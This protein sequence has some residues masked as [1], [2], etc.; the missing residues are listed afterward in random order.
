MP[1]LTYRVIVLKA[2]CEL[3]VINCY[4]Y[5][6]ALETHADLLGEYPGLH[7]YIEAI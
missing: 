2:G 1:T 5:E 4:C 6:R 3:V 7:V